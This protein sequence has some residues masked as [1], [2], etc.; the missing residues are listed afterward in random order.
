MTH[1][2]RL[3]LQ[4]ASASCSDVAAA[5]VLGDADRGAAVPLPALIGDEP[6]PGRPRTVT[7]AQVE[8][9]IVR[10]LETTP[11]D[12][13]HW[14]TPS[15]A[16]EVGPT[17]SAVHRIWRAFGLQPHRQETLTHLGRGGSVPGNGL[18]GEAPRGSV[19]QG[20]Y[21][22]ASVKRQEGIG[23]GSRW[24]GWVCGR[25]RFPGRARAEGPACSTDLVRLI[26]EGWLPQDPCSS[27]GS[28]PKIGRR[29]AHS[30]CS[31]ARGWRRGG[32]RCARARPGNRRGVMCRASGWRQSRVAASQQNAASS[33]AHAIATVPVGLPRRWP[34]CA[35]RACRRRCARDAIST[36]RGS[37]PAWAGR[38]AVADRRAATVVVGCFDEQPARVRRAGLC[39]RALHALAVRR[40]LARHDPEE[41]G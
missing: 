26:C 23:G 28:H 33:R 20:S 13:T 16:A 10:T 22:G 12:T 35:Q 19:D 24:L 41:P 9:V 29:V 40:V 39:D 15:L 37:W 30:L 1:R 27:P 21:G 31:R 34:R 5:A 11:R 17:K 4:I 3:G 2:R 6:R 14:S 36:T 18:G 25:W 32:L 8:E 7:D 38:E